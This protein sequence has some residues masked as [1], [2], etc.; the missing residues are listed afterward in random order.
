MKKSIYLLITAIMLCSISSL[1][2]TISSTV[3][4]VDT[5]VHPAYTF[6]IGVNKL[7]NRLV[8]WD[9]VSWKYL[10]K[11]L[12]DTATLDFASSGATTVSD[13]T[14]SMPG[15]RLGMTVAVGAP[16]G[17]VTAT[18]SYFGWVSASNVVTIR[19]SP[20]ATENPSSG[21]FDISVFTY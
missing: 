9:K 6:R 12:H 20:K 7:D 21:V 17:S 5:S 2:Q 14:K 10:A 16:H 3:M 1:A 19:F 13:L 18:G 8:F 4:K 15:A 11:T